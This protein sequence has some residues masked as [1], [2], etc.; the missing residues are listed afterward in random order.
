MIE[1]NARLKEIAYELK[2]SVNTVS[3]ALR[4]CSDISKKTKERVLQKAIEL[5]YMPNSVSQAIKRDEKKLIAILINNFK[6][7]FFTCMYERFAKAFKEENVDFTIIYEDEE[8][9]SEDTIKQCIN[10][11]VDGIITFYEPDSNII[12]LA[13][14][15]NIT[16]VYLGR[17]A[18]DVDINQ[19]YTDDEQGG[20]LA[21]NYLINYH[22]LTNFLYVGYSNIPNSNVRFEKFKET[23]ENINPN[24]VV[25]Y[26]NYEQGMEL[27]ILK[28]AKNGSLGFFGFND[29]LVY[30]V[31]SDMN[32]IVPSIRKV[33]PKLHI[34]GFDS[35]ATNINGLTDLTSIC[36]DFNLMC[37]ESV[38]ILIDSFKNKEFNIKKVVI[39]VSLHQRIYFN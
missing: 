35:L 31:I 38:K 8:K 20:I 27:D 14:Y 4:D 15:N 39:P 32:L 24:A 10:Q 1:K 37:S 21:A 3:R 34:V 26:I 19:V 2:L 6:N 23:I 28:Y 16:L 22:N 33:F 7:L 11:R 17:C 13:R 25:N 36:F 5:G 12:N 29:E 30:N 9:V 18:E